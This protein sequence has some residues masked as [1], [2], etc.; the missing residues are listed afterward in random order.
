MNDSI[1][2]ENILVGDV[3]L[4]SGQSNME[5][6][7]RGALNSKEEVAAADY[8]SI[9]HIKVERDS[10]AIP[11]RDIRRSKGWQVCQ[12]DKAGEFTAVGYFFAR[13][14]Y[15]YLNVPIGLIN[16][17]WG[18]TVIEPWTAPEGFHR[19]PELAPFSEKIKAVDPSTKPGKAAHLK[20]ISEVEAWLGNAKEAVAAGTYPDELPKLPT[21]G[22]GGRVPTHLYNAMIHPLTPFGIKGVIWYQGESNG[23]EGVTYLHKMTALIKGWREVWNHDGDLPFYF[24][25]LAN[26]QSSPHKPEGGDGWAALREAQRKTLKLNKT[27]MAVIIDIGNP[28]DIHPKNKQDVGKRL[29]RWALADTYGQNIVPSGPLF[30]KIEIHGDRVR[31]Y[32]KHTGSGLMVG[33]KEGLKPTQE[34]PNGQLKEFAIAGADQVWHWADAVIEGQKVIVSSRKVANPVAVRYAYRMNPS[35]ANLYS[36][37]GLPASPFRSDDW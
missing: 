31:V 11:L 22:T 30:D 33:H 17:S 34:M 21:I 6:T 36:K 25:Q 16:S 13:Q 9:R 32:F 24:V 20:T 27:G 8:P 1:R 29:A 26:F 19:V 14:L 37:Q 35:E 10:S 18:G 28:K 15:Q 2:L 23:K 7:L 3:W 12:P 4:C 5:W